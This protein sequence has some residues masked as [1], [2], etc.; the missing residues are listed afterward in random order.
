M[1][2]VERVTPLTDLM[3]PDMMT[4]V[5]QSWD[6]VCKDAPAPRLHSYF[7]L[8]TSFVLPLAFY[9][10]HI[11]LP[12]RRAFTSA[13]E[14]TAHTLTPHDLSPFLASTSTAHNLKFPFVLA[15]LFTY[16]LAY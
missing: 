3:K 7:P 14:H 9:F 16:I 4:K 15:H 8:H 13:L 11:V 10:L 6:L 1:R 5:I 12:Q 2:M